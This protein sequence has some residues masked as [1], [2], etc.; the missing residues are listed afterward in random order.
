MLQVGG[1]LHR[2]QGLQVAG[3]GHGEGRFLEQLLG[4]DVGIVAGTETDLDIALRERQVIQRHRQ[5]QLDHDLRMALGEVGN[6]RHEQVA[7]EGR[8]QHHLDLGLHGRIAVGHREI[9]QR[10]QALRTTSR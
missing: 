2:R 8:R 6:A 7:R 4:D 9:G 1:R 10:A 5:I 3:A